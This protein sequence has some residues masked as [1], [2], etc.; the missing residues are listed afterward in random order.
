MDGVA[1]LVSVPVTAAGTASASISTLAPGAHQLTAVYS[2]D[3]YS[4]AST[5]PRL[6]QQVAQRTTVALSSSAN[7]ALLGDTVQ[8]TINV[9][10]GVAASPPT[11]S[12]ILTDGNVT[13][14]TLTLSNGAANYIWP[15]PALGQHSLSA[16]YSGD[17]QNSATTSLSLLQTVTLRPTT[18]TL[19]TSA[20]TLSAGQ[21]LILISVVQ[22]SGSRLPGG[23]ITFRS[24]QTVLGTA[25]LDP[26][27]VAT[28]TIQPTQSGIFPTVAEYSGDALF[29]TSHSPVVSLTVNPTVEFAMTASPSMLKIQSG[30]HATVTIALT[31]AAT[32]KDTLAF[33]CAGLPQY[34]TCTWSENQVQVGGG[35]PHTL[36]V[37][38]DTGNPLGSGASASGFDGRTLPGIFIGTLLALL[39]TRKRPRFRQALLGMLLLVTLGMATGCGTN[40]TQAKTAPGSYTFELIG[41]GNAT[42]ATQKTGMLLT[43]TQ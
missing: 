9:G 3:P 22:G 17:A 24:G 38:I 2:G 40:F 42:G 4:N 10:N 35:L 23:S 28:L 1:A 18:T 12:V 21:T 13:L 11:G 43:V 7:P 33:G 39:L 34:A 30:S 8:L 15:A 6:T 5:S 32:F 19:T 27:G 37:V 25:A 36:S 26:A 29:A 31:T 16:S 20:S 41:T 14:A